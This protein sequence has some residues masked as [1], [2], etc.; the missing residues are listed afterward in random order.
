MEEGGEKRADFISNSLRIKQKLMSQGRDRNE[1]S[2]LSE[3]ERKKK[4]KK[5]KK[6]KGYWTANVADPAFHV[7]EIGS[8]KSGSYTSRKFGSLRVQTLL[9]ESVW[10]TFLI[11]RF[12]RLR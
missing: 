9:T 5:K 8:E 3:V 10:D 2:R 1:K 6:W 4:E 12:L 11:P 7:C